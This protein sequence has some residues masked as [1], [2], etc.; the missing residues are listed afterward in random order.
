MLERLPNTGHFESEEVR[1][2]LINLLYT[3]RVLIEFKKA[4]GDV[5]KLIGELPNPVGVEEYKPIDLTKDSFPVI[6]VQ[7]EE[8]NNWR[9]IRWDSILEITVL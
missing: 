3:K 5:R 2:W 4:N 7:L 8:E 1:Q 9:S 6:D